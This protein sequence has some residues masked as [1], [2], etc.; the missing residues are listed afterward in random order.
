MSQRL[1]S[2][3]VVPKHKKTVVASSK[4][5]IVED[6]GEILV[7]VRDLDQKLSELGILTD[8]IQE[9]E[10][11]EG[12]ITDLDV[13]TLPTSPVF[14]DGK[15]I[16]VIK[17]E[18]TIVEVVKEELIVD[19]ALNSDPVVITVDELPPEPAVVVVEDKVLED[20][21]EVVAVV[22]KAPEAVVVG[23]IVVVAKKK[24]GRPKKVKVEE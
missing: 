14:V 16:P 8:F 3:A 1:P 20:E 7:R 19:T 23:D 22:E 13:I 9:P 17:V 21:D 15:V 12:S 24:A 5:W 18:D 2:W 10:I 11:G 4:G 6:T